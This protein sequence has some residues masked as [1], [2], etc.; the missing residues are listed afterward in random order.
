MFKVKVYKIYPKNNP[1]LWYL[2]DAPSKRIAKWCGAAVL[3]NTYAVFLAAKDMKAEP[4]ECH[5]NKEE[6]YVY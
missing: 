4:W 1:D 5:E 3:N 6:E 2:V